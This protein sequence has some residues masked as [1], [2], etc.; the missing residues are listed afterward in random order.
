MHHLR[1]TLVPLDA[2]YIPFTGTVKFHFDMWGNGIAGAMSMEEMGATGRVH[3]SDATVARPST[4][5]CIGYRPET[6]HVVTLGHP[7]TLTDMHMHMHMHMDVV[8][9]GGAK[10]RALL[11]GGSAPPPRRAGQRAR[12]LP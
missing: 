4:E 8:A 3:V 7:V 9:G 6:M 1:F 5:P 2:L 10:H 12:H 11:G